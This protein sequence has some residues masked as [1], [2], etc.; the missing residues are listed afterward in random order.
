MAPLA[1]TKNDAWALD[2]IKNALLLY[3]C[4]TI[5]QTVSVFDSDLDEL[6]SYL[7]RK[8]VVRDLE[9]VA[10]FEG[11]IYL[12]NS[13]L[14][15]FA[16]G[17]YE[18][19]MKHLKQSIP[20]SRWPKWVS[21]D[22]SDKTKFMLEQLE[23]LILCQSHG[24]ITQDIIFPRNSKSEMFEDGCVKLTG[25][26]LI[27][28]NTTTFEH[29]ESVRNDR[30]RH[31]KIRRLTGMLHEEFT[32]WDVSKIED[33]LSSRIEIYENNAK[34]LGL[35]LIDATVK[36]FCGS[37]I[38]GYVAALLGISLIEN[39]ILTIGVAAPMIFEL[40]KVV[41]EFRMSRRAL[42]MRLAEDPIALLADA[43]HVN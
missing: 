1:Q 7:E 6:R 38:P 42:R 37:K 31:Q 8:R 11:G 20:E 19:S 9:T 21:D 14:I 12:G 18:Y 34:Y 32:G 4:V 15:D 17:M 2:N 23:K 36:D 40:G 10:E 16:Y 13:K 3:D 29:L 26:K 25:L 41:C 33:E 39:P 22:D 43:R 5:P 24:I 27:D 28:S 30:S 35:N